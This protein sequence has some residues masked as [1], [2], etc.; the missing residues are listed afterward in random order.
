LLARYKDKVS[1]YNDDIQGTAG[2]ALTGLLSALRVAGGKLSDQR[3]LFLGAG[4]AGIGIA[5]LI[6][7]GMTLDGLTESQARSR[8]SLF[9]INGLLESSRSDLYDFQKPYA[10]PHASTRDF[11]GAIESL[12]PTAIIGVSTRGKAFSKPVV[13]AMARLNKRPIIFA[14]SNPTEHAECT[15]EEAYR[16]SEGQALYAA[17]VPFPPFRFGDKTIVPSQGNNLYVFPAVG[18]AIYAT[19]AKRVIDEMFVVAAQAVAD[20]VT[21]TEL[22]VGLLYP[23]QSD[24][25]KTEITAAVEVTKVIF[26]RGLAGAGVEKPKDV[27]AFLDGQLYQPEYLNFT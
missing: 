5:N 4:S 22:E 1:C 21:Q 27:R 8:I 26:D 25:L 11:L 2:A 18:L 23:P 17:G 9:D 13:E 16:W 3:I 24:I 10:H 7:S 6:A 20:Q 14:Y 15:A 12:R 19:K